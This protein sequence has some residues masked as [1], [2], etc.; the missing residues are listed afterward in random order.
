MPLP[1]G[2]WCEKRSPNRTSG[3]ASREEAAAPP[4]PRDEDHR[5]KEDEMSQQEPEVVVDLDQLPVDEDVPPD[6]GDAGAEGSK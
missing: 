2:A 4:R 3:D 5:R 6:E 1:G